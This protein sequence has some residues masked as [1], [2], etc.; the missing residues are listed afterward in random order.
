MRIISLVLIFGLFFVACKE[1]TSNPTPNLYFPPNNTSEWAKI[2]PAELGWNTAQIPNLRNF[3]ISNN[4]RAFIVLKDGKI[5]IEEYFGTALTGGGAFGA[6]SSWYWASAGKTLTGFL[7]GIAQQ[8]KHLNIQEKTSQ[9]LGAGWSSLTLNQEN[10]ITIRHQLTMT[11]GLDDGV[12]NKDCTDP[13]CLIYLTPANT[14]WAYHNAPYTILDQ[15]VQNAVG[16]SFGTYFNAK[17]RDKIGMDGF[18]NKTSDNNV[19]FSTPRAMARFG[20]LLLN[21]GDWNGEAILSDKDYGQ[22]MTQTSQNF[23]LAY[24]YLT[25]L[26]G[27][28]TLMVPTLQTVFNGSISPN[29]PADMYAAMGKNGQLINV[30]PSQNLVMIRMG[31]SPDNS[32]V[33]FTFQDELWARLKLVISQ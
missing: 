2:S 19:Y 24:G 23:N 6:N 32:L 14:R 15:V 12:A 4:T 9:Y 31:D 22:A 1:N 5:V 16:Q 10:Q 25:W 7:V 8:E 17:I 30:V 21:Q 27:K 3:L 28:N 26:N 29:A 13:A 18:W 33:P 11:T 20:L